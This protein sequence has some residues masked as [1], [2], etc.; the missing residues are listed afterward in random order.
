MCMCVAGYW[1]GPRPARPA[2]DVA[3][4]LRGRILLLYDKYLSPDG[5]AVR[6]KALKQDP[7]FWEYVDATAELQR[8]RGVCC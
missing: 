5:K 4:D 2:E 7:A 8:V 3:E 1:W 6:Y